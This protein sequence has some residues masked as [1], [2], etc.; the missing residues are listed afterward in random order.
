MH[1]FFINLDRHP[2][3]RAHL[4]KQLQI[5]GIS[6]ERVPGVDGLNVP[7]ELS[8][9]YDLGS[10]GRHAL[11]P[12]EIGCHASHMKIW[13]FI[14]EQGLDHA[15]VL[16]DD[17]TLPPNLEALIEEIVEALPDTWDVVR[18]CRQSK[19]SVRP[20]KALSAG[21]H[22]VRY[23]RVPLGSAGYLVSGRGARKLL[24]PRIVRNPLDKEISQAWLFD[25]DVYGVVPNPIFQDN[26][27]LASTIGSNRGGL[28][29]LQRMRM[30]ATKV[31]YN[32]SKLGPTWWARCCAQN[33]GMKLRILAPRSRDRAV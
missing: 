27:A 10:A 28:P 3:R 31:R 21:R 32:L 22:L 13:N 20:L 15:L 5:G 29:P 1:A 19:S 6:A 24:R 17:A 2:E 14:V 11:Q 16:E 26:V 9:Y 8:V 33:L 12:N 25:L 4:E 18:L 23:S 7:A 30:G